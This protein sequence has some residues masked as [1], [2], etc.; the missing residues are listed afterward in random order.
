[1]VKYVA[2]KVGVPVWAVYAVVGVVVVVFGVFAV[3][4]SD[5]PPELVVE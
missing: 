5:V 1:M 2:D 3:F 4:G